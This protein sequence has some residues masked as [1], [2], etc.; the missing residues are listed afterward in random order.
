VLLSNLISYGI[1]PGISIQ[2]DALKEEYIRN[3]ILVGNMDK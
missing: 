2:L 1:E 3:I